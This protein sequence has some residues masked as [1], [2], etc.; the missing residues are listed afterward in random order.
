MKD[1]LPFPSEDPSEERFIDA[2]LR[3]HHRLGGAD[4]DSDL[5]SSI[6]RETVNRV[7]PS[8]VLSE[9]RHQDRKLWLI[10]ASSA[11]AIVAAIGTVLAILPFRSGSRDV[12]EI[13]FVV[14]YAVEEAPLE[15]FSKP[16]PQREAS[17]LSSPI[18][19]EKDTSPLETTGPSLPEIAS[20]QPTFPPSF[21]EVPEPTRSEQRLRIEADE[22]HHSDGRRVYEGSVEVRHDQFRVESEF[23]ELVTSQELEEEEE[24][25]LVSSHALLEQASPMRMALADSLIYEPSLERFTLRGVVFLETAEGRL[26]SFAPEDVVFL[27]NETLVVQKSPQVP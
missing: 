3:E 18:S 9:R 5:V 13:R 8:P 15:L 27:T 21:S 16:A 24:V 20:I 19:F 26:N 25:K 6:L 23:V 12:E 14:Q 17:P 7:D 10:G 4:R 1:F 2:A 22:T 11:A